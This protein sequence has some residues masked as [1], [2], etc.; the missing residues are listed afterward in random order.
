MKRR[1]ANTS[2]TNVAIF[3]DISFPRTC[4]G[5]DYNTY[6]QNL[7]AIVDLHE[8]PGPIHVDP[9]DPRKHT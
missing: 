1:R 5:A 2:H 8:I 6:F 7:N 4:S 9:H 3:K